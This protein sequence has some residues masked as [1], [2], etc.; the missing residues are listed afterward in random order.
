MAEKGIEDIE[1]VDVDLLKGE[2]KQGAYRERAGLAH[3]PAFELDD[4]LVLTESVAI[5]RYLEALHPEPNLFGLGA[6]ETAIIEM[7][8]RRCELYL[9]NPLMLA[10]RYGHPALAVLEGMDEG[11][12]HKLRAD[13]EKM[14][15]HVER[16]LEGREFIAADRVTMADIVA[17]TGMDFA[18]LI[19]WRPPETLTNV[20]RW[21]EAMRARPAA[22]AGL[23]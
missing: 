21:Y 16:Q 9:A 3:V 10:V 8:M 11:A 7:W 20:A 15:K 18:R 1:I 5:C 4:G 19:R 22:Q 13:A 17:V 6:R 23:A 14:L 12:S 2:H